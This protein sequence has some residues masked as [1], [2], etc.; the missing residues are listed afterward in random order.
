MDLGREIQIRLSCMIKTVL[1]LPLVWEWERVLGGR[2]PS[3]GGSS[4]SVA[5]LSASSCEVRVCLSAK[6]RAGI[7]INTEGPVA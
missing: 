4:R 2:I 1:C 3:W 7:I 6:G 5:L